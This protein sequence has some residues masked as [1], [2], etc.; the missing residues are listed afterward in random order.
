M[1]SLPA[2]LLAAMLVLPGSLAAEPNSTVPPERLE[3][4]TRGA[5][6]SW[7]FA[8][9]KIDPNHI[10][11]FMTADDFRLIRECGFRYVRLI[12]DPDVMMDPRDA[13]RLQPEYVALLDGVLDAILAE[14]LA[15]V[16]CPFQNDGPKARLF[17]DSRAG[18]A[19]A[20]F[21]ESFAAHLSRRDP[22]AVFLQVMN[23]PNIND[24]ALWNGTQ[25]RLV[26]RIRKGAPAH[27]I[28]AEGNIRCDGKW[29]HIGGFECL[30][31]V[32][33]KNVVY[34]F[35]FYDPVQFTHQGATWTVP[36]CRFYKNL[37]YPSSPAAVAPLLGGLTDAGAKEFAR[38]YGADGW[39]KARVARA[40]K[41]VLNWRTKYNVP[42]VCMEFGLSHANAPDPDRYLYLRDVREVLEENGIGWGIWDYG[43]ELFGVARTWKDGRRVPDLKALAALGLSAPPASQPASRPGSAPAR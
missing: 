37:P 27:T 9:V 5:N 13:A 26:E 12:V 28:V 11:T 39:N 23:E 14:R 31:P 38:Q 43:T 42:V 1:R 21:W 16:V 32:K 33:D 15:V 10:K 18:A 8:Q 41:P 40:L 35:H 30:R 25:G 3:R 2:A 17:T 7:W 19:F 34:D 20:T 4:L 22:N 24:Q 6:L 29:N 36:R